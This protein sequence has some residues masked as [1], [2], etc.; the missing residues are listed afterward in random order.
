MFMKHLDVES[1]KALQD[2]TAAKGNL[3][4][5][6]K[7]KH[8]KADV[9]SFSKQPPWELAYTMEFRTNLTKTDVFNYLYYSTIK[10]KNSTGRQAAINAVKETEHHWYKFNRRFNNVH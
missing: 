9:W 4:I 5:A 6:H 3:V 10:L 1:L 2:W 8:D 7:F